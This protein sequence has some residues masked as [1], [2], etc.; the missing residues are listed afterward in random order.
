MDNPNIFFTMTVK[1]IRKCF[2]FDKL[3]NFVNIIPID[4]HIDP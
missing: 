1:S 2:D 4:M 3:I